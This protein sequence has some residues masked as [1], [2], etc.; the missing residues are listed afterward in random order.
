MT[1]GSLIRHTGNRLALWGEAYDTAVLPLHPNYTDPILGDLVEIDKENGTLKRYEPKT[2]SSGWQ[3]Y[4]YG[5]VIGEPVRE[6]PFGG[7]YH[8]RATVAV[9]GEGSELLAYQLNKNTGSY[10]DDGGLVVGSRVDFVHE[11]VLQRW[12]IQPV[13]LVIEPSLPPPFRIVRLVQ[14]PKDITGYVVRFSRT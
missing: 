13:F 11:T 14:K 3:V 6:S 10:Y 9:L 1:R 2:E 8:R 4:P 12:G 5:I 7:E